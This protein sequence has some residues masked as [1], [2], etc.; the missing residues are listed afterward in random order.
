MKK[1]FK[2]MTEEEQIAF[3]NEVGRMYMNGAA[4]IQA[5]AKNAN[6]D[7]QG[8]PRITVYDSGNPVETPICDALDL[9]FEASKQDIMQNL[10]FMTILSSG[11]KI[12]KLAVH[13][14]LHDAFCLGI[15]LMTEMEMDFD[16]F[17]D[18]LHRGNNENHVE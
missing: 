12:L 16:G 4:C 2:E 13:Q 6:E 5:A 10:E 3:A 9:L 18:F 11:E 14:A 17:S 8:W 1:F 7:L 15:S